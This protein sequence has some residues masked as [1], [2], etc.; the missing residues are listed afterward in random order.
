MLGY[1]NQPAITINSSAF[2]NLKEFKFPQAV[3]CSKED[4]TLSMCNIFSERRCSSYGSLPAAVHCVDNTV[5]KETDAGGIIK[6]M[7]SGLPLCLKNNAEAS[8]ICTQ[9]AKDYNSIIKIVPGGIV[10]IRDELAAYSIMNKESNN[11][12]ITLVMVNHNTLTILKMIVVTI[13]PMI[14]KGN[15]FDVQT[16]L[17]L[18]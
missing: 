16:V 6:I 12:C 18:N 11:V 7:V 17:S 1:E 4:T 9:R 5:T 3:Q 13:F 8:K 14:V 15:N 2:T 10:S